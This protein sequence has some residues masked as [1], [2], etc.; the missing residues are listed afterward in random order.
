MIDYTVIITEPISRFHSREVD[1]EMESFPWHQ[2]FSI[3][4]Y[5]VPY[6]Y[7]CISAYLSI[8]TFILHAFSYEL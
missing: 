7:N 3:R 4:F 1:R 2:Q 8:F 6:M 5:A